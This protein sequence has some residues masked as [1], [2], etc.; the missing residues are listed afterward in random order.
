MTVRRLVV[1]L[2]L[3]I[4]VVLL[5]V[6]GALYGSV[7]DL[8]GTQR[9]AGLSDRVT[10]ERDARGAVTIRAKTQRDAAEALGFV[11]AQER[12]FQMDLQRRRAAGE[13][14]ALVGPK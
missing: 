4:A 2:V 5:G 12:F 6:A 14:A 10:I 11:H 8:S 3:V 7:A 9:I 1:A 13:L